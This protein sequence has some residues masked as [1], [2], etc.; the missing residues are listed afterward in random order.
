MQETDFAPLSGATLELRR[1]KEG[2]DGR[3]LV[4]IRGEGDKNMAKQMIKSKDS[5]IL[6]G[7][8]VPFPVKCVSQKSQGVK[9]QN[10]E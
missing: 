10:T 3:G 5:D 7:K 4:K 8:F 6:G 2:R 9:Y 1:H